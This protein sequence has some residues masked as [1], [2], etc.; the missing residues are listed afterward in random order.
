MGKGKYNPQ[1]LKE[2]RI[3]LKDGLSR[4]DSC[5]IGGISEETFYAWMRE[6]PEFSE[7]VLKWEIQGKHLDIK[8]LNIAGKNGN[9][10]AITFKLKCRWPEEFSERTEVRHSGGI[11]QYNITDSVF[12]AAKKSGPEA[13]RKLEDL[14]ELIGTEIVETDEDST[15]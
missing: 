11:K 2:I 7:N 1:T 6:K 10:A 15:S 8:R 13:E 12:D 9:V 14:L 4:K 5:V 3:G